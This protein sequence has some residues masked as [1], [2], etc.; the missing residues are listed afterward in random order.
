M[1]I[2]NDDNFLLMEATP[3]EGGFNA[4][5]VEAVASASGRKFTAAHDRLMMDSDEATVQRLAE[6]ADLKR[7]QFETE[8]TEGGWLRFQRD[9]HGAIV[10]RYRIGGWSAAAA[11][12][13]EILVDG[14][15]ANSFY[16]DFG[17]LLRSQR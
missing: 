4:L 6:F 3:L 11:M 17:A 2:G 14:E 15:F 8:F 5:R 13:G 7:D 12:E 16:R 1:R 9:S 10:V